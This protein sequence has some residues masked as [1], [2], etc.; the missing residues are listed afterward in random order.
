MTWFSP[1]GLFVVQPFSVV[2]ACPTKASLFSSTG[3]EVAIHSAGK[4]RPVGTSR[5]SE[6]GSIVVAVQRLVSKDRGATMAADP[7]PDLTLEVGHQDSDHVPGKQE[8]TGPVPELLARRELLI[9]REDRDRLEHIKAGSF[10]ILVGGPGCHVD[11]GLAV[12][13][14]GDEDQRLS[15]PPPQTRHVTHLPGVGLP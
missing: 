6:D 15:R 1:A 4:E 9:G 14:G 8:G 3:C 5:Q 12:L 10:L 2:S 7:L 11:P 13:A